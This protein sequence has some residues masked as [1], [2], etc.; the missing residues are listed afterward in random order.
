MSEKSIQVIYE[1]EN[2]VAV[3]KPSGLVVHSD[4]KTKEETLVD[5]VLGKYPEIKEVGEPVVLSNGIK[6]YRPG[7]VHRLDRET[8]GVIVV[9]KNQETFLFLKRQFQDRR[10]KK[11]YRAI[12]HG[13]FKKNRGTIDKP[14][15]KNKKDFRVWSV[16]NTRG[17][18]RDAVT[19][20]KV[21]C[22]LGDFSYIEVYPKTGRT[23]QI[24]VHMKSIQRPIVGDKLYSNK[25]DNSLGINRVALHALSL[26]LSLRGG[27]ELKI[28]ASLPDDFKKALTIMGVEDVLEG[29]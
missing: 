15:G 9:A 7:I 29:C 3:N 18:L 8:S 20:Y 28:E 4:G 16:V 2:I 22:S 6:I 1:D 13:K 17:V 10:I 21:L 14:I 24:R 11:V 12:V 19:Q 25:E 27:R 23:H 5:W 26:T